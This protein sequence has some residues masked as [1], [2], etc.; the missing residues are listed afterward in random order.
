M[1]DF[2]PI[3]TTRALTIIGAPVRS[4]TKTHIQRPEAGFLA[5]IIA[6]EIGAAQHRARRRNTPAAAIAAYATASALPRSV[7]TLA[8]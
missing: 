6:C 1:S 8:A 2:A 7:F 3:P 4:E 5:H